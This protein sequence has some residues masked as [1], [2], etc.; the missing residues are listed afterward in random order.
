MDE[1]RKMPRYQR[2]PDDDKQ[3]LYDAYQR[4]EDYLDLAR[5][6]GI[7]RT[8]AWAIVKRA[9]ENDGE[10][11]R[12]RGGVRLQRVRVSPELAAAA[13]AVVEDHP[14]FTLDQLNSEVRAKLPNHPT[15]GRTTLAKVLHGQLVTMKKLEDAPGER[16]SDRVKEARFNFANWLMTHG[17]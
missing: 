13:V 15:V 14:E 8:T 16:N 1:T 10:V 6:L 9:D 2:I 7:K 4:G 5:Q 3:R 17:I 11:S 12:P